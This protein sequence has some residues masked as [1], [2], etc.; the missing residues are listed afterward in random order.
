MWQIEEKN[1]RVFPGDVT[2][3]AYQVFL[4]SYK[5]DHSYFLDVIPLDKWK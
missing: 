1:L 4:I 3:F 2:N 5:F